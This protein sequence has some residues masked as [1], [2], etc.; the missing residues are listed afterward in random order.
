M[1]RTPWT[2]QQR[3]VAA[4]QRWRGADTLIEAIER[5]RLHRTGRLSALV[6]HYAFLSVFPL[7]LVFTTSLGLL[8]EGD[9]AL[10]ADIID[11]VLASFPIIGETIA[12]DPSTLQGSVVLLVLGAL[13]ALWSGMRAFNVLQTAL[14]DIAEVPIDER[15]SLVRTRLRSLIGIALVGGGQVGAALISGV[16]TS[17]R[18]SWLLRLALATVTLVLNG[19]VAAGCYHWLVSRHL[20]WRSVV[21]GAVFGAVG[22]TVLQ[23]VGA[24]LMT[25]AIVRASP[26]YGTFATVIGLLFWFSLHAFT[27]LLGAEIN[28]VVAW[29]RRGRAVSPST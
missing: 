15:S 22:F 1:A 20:S 11:S 4:R 28:G 18:S 6:S 10:Q 17:E 25:R 14:D 13:T 7:M 12:N 26:V 2:E 27:A 19:A 3:V 21:P 8:L 24:A 16:V 5:F 9:P 29:H 23:V